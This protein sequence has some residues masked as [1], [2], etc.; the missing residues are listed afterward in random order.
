MSVARSS[1]TWPS[2]ISAELVAEASPAINFVRCNNDH[3]YWV[4]SRPWD[5]GRNVIMRLG[6]SGAVQELLPASFSNH[7]RVH[8]YGG[9]AYVANGEELFF[10]NGDDQRIYVQ[11]SSGAPKPISPEG[12]WRFADLSFDRLREQLIVVCEL[13]HEASEPSNFIA[14]ISLSEEDS[15][16]TKIKPLVTG[17]DFYA[18]PTLSPDC[19]TICWIQWSHPRMP[20]DGSELWLA[21]IG[22]NGTATNP[23]KVAGGDNEAIMQPKWSVNGDLF[24]ISDKTGWWNIYMTHKENNQ[25]N[26]A[27]K[28]PILS[29]SAD[30]AGPLW[31]LGASYYDF[32]SANEI[33]CI[34]SDKGFSYAGILNLSSRKL[35]IIKSS[36]SH[37]ESVA[38]KDGKFYCVAANFCKPHSVVALH[39]KRGVKSTYRPLS[40][41]KVSAL[42]AKSKISDEN[43]SEPIQIEFTSGNSSQVHAF[44]YQPTNCS[45]F[46]LR[47]ELP[48]LIV[49]CH[50]GPTAAATSARNLKIQ[51][52]TNRGFAVAD[53]NYRGSSGFGRYYREALLRK[54]G[55]ADV[56]DTTNLVHHL[57]ENNLVDAERCIIRGSSAGGYTVLAALTFTETFKA[58]ASYYGI[59]NLETLARDTHKFESQ[60]LESLV[61]SYAQERDLYR[62]R[63]PIYHTDHLNCPVIFFQGLQDNVVPANQARAMVD[64]LQKKGIRVEYVTYSDERHGFRKSANIIDALQKE[65]EFYQKTFGLGDLD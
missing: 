38:C 39:P 63:S 18:Y 37:F 11:D 43:F 15:Y 10:V 45:Y 46:P 42:L 21:E 3:L 59:G 56:E 49:T 14:I 55:L 58:G 57:A 6:V 62:A 25:F 19:K 44:F 35:S 34:W 50:G 13:S 51:Y 12:N 22:D 8:E 2:N 23:R 40:S 52:W 61:G 31:Q 4:E 9:C 30:F 28:E 29:I 20:W 16:K 64:I 47:D 53:L 54:W 27:G 36:Y 26:T 17:S 41:P 1:G 60:Y 24:Y 5:N 33:A 65:L 7:S 32:V 48:P